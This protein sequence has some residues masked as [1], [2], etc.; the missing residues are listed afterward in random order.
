MPRYFFNVRH[1]PGPAGLAEDREGDE[2][3]DVAAAREHALSE[4]KAVIAR[5]RLAT[6]RDW[7]DCSFEITDGD[8]QLVL[9][10]PFSDTVQEQ[11]ED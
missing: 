6:I 1:R 4:A 10:V 5:D 8:G 2:L 7:M 9:T 3:V 11:D